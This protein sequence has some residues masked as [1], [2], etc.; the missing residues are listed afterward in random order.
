MT[1]GAPIKKLSVLSEDPS[2]ET[3]RALKVAVEFLSEG[4]Y[5]VQ[6]KTLQQELSDYE[7]PSDLLIIVDSNSSSSDSCGTLFLREYWAILIRHHIQFIPAVLII[8]SLSAKNLKKIDGRYRVLDVEGVMLLPIP[9]DMGDILKFIGLH[10]NDPIDFMEAKE[11][12]RESCEKSNTYIAH[13][14]KNFYAPYSLLLGAY[15]AGIFENREEEYLNALINLEIRQPDNKELM[16]YNAILF[17]DFKDAT[18]SFPGNLNPPE[19][20]T[21]I[22]KYRD[23]RIL[24]ID[25]DYYDKKVSISIWESVFNAIFKRI[26]VSFDVHVSGVSLPSWRSSNEV[27]DELKKRLIDNADTLLPFDLILLDLYLTEDDKKIAESYRRGLTDE[28]DLKNYTSFR[29][30]ECVRRTKEDPIPVVLFTATEKVYNLKILQTAGIDAYFPKNLQQEITHAGKYYESFVDCLEPLLTPERMLLRDIY[31][32]IKWFENQSTPQYSQEQK[33]T[34]VN[35]LKS[36]CWLLMKDQ[37]GGALRGVIIV[38]GLVIEMIWQRS[39]A[40]LN[41]YGH[42]Q[43]RYHDKFKAFICYQIRC[44]AK[45]SNQGMR[46]EDAF[47]ILINILDILNV[48]LNNII[49]YDTCINWNL[50]EKNISE[51]V[52]S[53]CSSCTVPCCSEYNWGPCH[54]QTDI[55]T[56]QRAAYLSIFRESASDNLK[57]NLVPF[58]YYYY[59]LELF[60]RAEPINPI[61]RRLLRKRLTDDGNFCPPFDGEWWGVKFDATGNIID[62]PFGVLQPDVIAARATSGVKLNPRFRVP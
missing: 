29:F 2:N 11:Y 5:I 51:M 6:I 25:D 8:S 24:V 60:K 28:H 57:K 15:R 26:R 33:E 49:Y 17:N 19:I 22:R 37:S 3:C 38:L 54:G 62:S 32:K 13:D 40:F 7:K 56:S 34:M 47:F 27:I 43:H 18:G 20:F 12:L 44:L 35:Y 41:N 39:R 46:A 30:L 61:V 36:S 58:L 53:I 9:F 45:H 23:V 1:N 52:D 59:L 31:G 55:D 14:M 16:I 21:K 42:G 50:N 48:R 10:L 4:K